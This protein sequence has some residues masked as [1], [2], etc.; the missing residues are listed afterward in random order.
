[1]TTPQDLRASL[2]QKLGNL[3]GRSQRMED[4][5]RHAD[6]SFPDDW[7]DRV[8]VLQ[9]D[10]VLEALDAETRAEIQQIQGALQRLRDGT[11][12]VCL[13]CGDP[14]A[15]GRLHAIPVT[16]TCADCAS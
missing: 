14:I 6:G 8:T 9:G 11:Y 15:P 2:E 1:M 10:E 3:L 5:L 12:G 7:E 4:R 16:T 13:V